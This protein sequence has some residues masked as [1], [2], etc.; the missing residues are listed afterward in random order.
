MGPPRESVPIA[1]VDA[2]T[3]EP[4][5]G[6]PAAV[7]LLREPASEAWM[8]GLA[9]E[10]NLSETAYVV[11]RGA[12][13]D[14]TRFDLR[15]FTP[16]V[17]VDLCGH[18]TLASAHVLFESGHVDRGTSIVFHTRSGELYATGE[19]GRVE[20][21]FPLNE[22]AE[23]EAPVG[24]A[25]A[26]GAP[27]AAYAVT[28]DDHHLVE[29]ADASTLRALS[30]DLDAIRQSLGSVCVTAA[31]DDERYDFVSRYFAPAYGIDEDPVTGSAHCLLAPYWSRRLG[32]DELTGY[33][34]SACC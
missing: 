15:W 22:P 8:Q 16:T 3:D 29:V 9:A 6:N 32:R 12:V 1:Q 11:P 7:C 20:L 27:I 18:A 4:F 34:A 28:A 14:D 19:P 5:H 25:D 33:Q 17:E 30:P 2:F 10:M 24:L 23:E 31:S 21:D 26:L 13:G